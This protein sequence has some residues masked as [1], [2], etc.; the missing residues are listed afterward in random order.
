MVIVRIILW[1]TDDSMV[2]TDNDVL[3]VKLN[4][5]CGPHWHFDCGYF[6][7]YSTC[8]ITIVVYTIIILLT[9][10]ML[11]VHTTER[12]SNACRLTLTIIYDQG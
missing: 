8:G 9:S 2:H 3:C 12:A 10:K 6:S 4:C 5:Q 11:I 1:W 7:F